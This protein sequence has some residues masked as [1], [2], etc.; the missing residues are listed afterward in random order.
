MPTTQVQ[1]QPTTILRCSSLQQSYVAQR[2]SI[3]VWPKPQR[4]P[5]ALPLYALDEQ[6]LRIYTKAHN[7]VPNVNGR[8]PWVS[9]NHKRT[10]RQNGH[11]QQLAVSFDA[12]TTSCGME[13]DFPKVHAD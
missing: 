3:P 11:G 7:V 6:K 9:Y 12:S 4:S 8:T 1:V 5:G 2:L 13:M 10:P